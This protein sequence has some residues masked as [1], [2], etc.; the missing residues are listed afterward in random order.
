MTYKAFQDYY[1]SAEIRH[2]ILH[3]HQGKLVSP[4]FCTDNNKEYNQYAILDGNNVSYIELDLPPATSK[5]NAICS[6]GED[7]WFVPYGIWDSFPYVVQIAKDG[8]VYHKLDSKGEGQFYSIATNGSDAFSFPLGYKE[9]NFC[10]HIKD[11]KV[12]T[13]PIPDEGQKLHM[14]TVFCNGSYW[15]LPRSEHPGYSRLYEFDSKDLNYYELPIS[16]TSTQITR[17]Y[18][19][20]IVKGNTLYGLP[21]GETKGLNTIIEFNTDTK[22]FNTYDVNFDF[23]KKYNWGVL[24]GDHI[25]ALP[26]GDEH[27]NDSNL[28]LIFNTVTK[29]INTFEINYSFG[30][31]YRYRSGIARKAKALFL[32]AGTLECPIIEVDVNGT[33]KEKRYDNLLFSR[34]V[35]HN[36]QIYTIVYNVITKENTVVKVL[37]NLEIETVAQL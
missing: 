7:V 29:E 18:T 25:V 32:P 23:A 21:F 15:S 35:E 26:Y 3:S 13:L 36:S 4:P 14:G 24:V 11:N 6:I 34:P 1:K 31:K 17:K 10:I 27:F 20:I 5:T 2:F 22:S 28:G 33:Y 16:Y 19:D 8:P 37:D 12:N 9:T 30:G